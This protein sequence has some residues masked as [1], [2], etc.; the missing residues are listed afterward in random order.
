[1]CIITTEDLEAQRQAW[2]KVTKT[3]IFARHSSH[4]KQ[5]IAYSLSIVST[6]TAAMILPLPV[7]AGSDEN[8]LRFINL[9]D[10]PDFFDDLSRVCL[11]EVEEIMFDL[12][13]DLDAVSAG[14][15]PPL[16]TVEEVG[17]YEASYVPSMEDF[18][19]LDP[20]FRLP[21]KV[22]HKMPDYADY[23]FA[24]FQLKID[25]SREDQEIENTIHP[26]AFE[27]PTRDSKKLFFP[28][29][30]VH[31]GDFHDQAGF[32]HKFY[33]QREN[34]RSEFKFQRD[35]FEKNEPTLPKILSFHGDDYFGGYAWF[36]Q[37]QD[38]AGNIIPW[39]DSE[40]LIDPDKKLYAMDLMGNYPN[41]DMWLGKALKTA[42]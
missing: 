17:D 3:N 11:P 8:A 18:K 10:Y 21:D 32:Y 31:D 4:E 7:L 19:R 1:M 39:Q 26:M 29:V 15:P 24:V 6:S 20:R 22:W 36:Y 2:L 5:L 35:Q 30:H 38:V 40:G 23:G 25:L 12:S 13:D 28:T 9:K 14:A 42:K 27:F 34:A 16:L 33:C 41:H 37:S